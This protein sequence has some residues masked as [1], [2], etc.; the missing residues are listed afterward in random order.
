VDERSIRGIFTLTKSPFEKVNTFFLF[1][2]QYF[3]FI[4]SAS[5]N[6]MPSKVAQTLKVELNTSG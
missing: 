5:S 6:E 4:R 3:S 1:A 2:L